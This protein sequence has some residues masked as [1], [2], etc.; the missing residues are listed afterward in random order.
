[1]DNLNKSIEEKNCYKETNKNELTFTRAKL[2][3]KDYL[4]NILDRKL[5][6]IEYERKKFKPNTI[7]HHQPLRRSNLLR[8]L[9]SLKLSDSEEELE[10]NNIKNNDIENNNKN[11]NTYFRNKNFLGSSIK[12]NCDDD[13][14]SDFY[15][16]KDQI[17]DTNT[18]PNS[19]VYEKYYL[20]LPKKEDNFID[21]YIHEINKARLNCK[22][23]SK[24]IE[25][26]ILKIQIDKDTKE[27][28]FMFNNEKIYINSGA[29]SLVECIKYLENL[30]NKFKKDKKFLKEIKNIEE[31]KMPFPEDIEK[32][33]D[34]D[35]IKKEMKKLKEKLKGKYRLKEFIYKKF[36][37]N[38]GQILGILSLISSDMNNDI[39]NVIFNTKIKY[40]GINYKKIDEKSSIVYINFAT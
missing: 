24:E 14:N 16:D 23:Y 8:S 30:Y 9:K 32:W 4:L 25:N 35:T 3:T 40:I 37:F 19:P 20:V 39:R 26:L 29:L 31:L 1:M 6:N 2:I 38:D 11:N 36:N 18:V 27:Q 22:K 5:P 21:D 12:Y 33:N 10:K 34:E 17:K 7:I 13:N 28:F 15:M